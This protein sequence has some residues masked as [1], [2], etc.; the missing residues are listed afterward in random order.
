MSSYKLEYIS[1]IIFSF[2]FV[3]FA[4]AQHLVYKKYF[5]KKKLVGFRKINLKYPEKQERELVSNKIISS[6]T[7]N[8]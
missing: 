6:G 2:L 8:Y 3:V 5:S 7:L 4:L 1:I